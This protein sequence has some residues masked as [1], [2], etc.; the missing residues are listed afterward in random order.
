MEEVGAREEVGVASERE[1][2]LRRVDAKEGG[3]CS[4]DAPPEGRG[5]RVDAV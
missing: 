1:G 3:G 4:A 5:R 2:G